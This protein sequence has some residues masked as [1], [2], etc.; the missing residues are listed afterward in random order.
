MDCVKLHLTQG[1]VEQMDLEHFEKHLICASLHL[2][3]SLN[4]LEFAQSEKEV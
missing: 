4:L 1:E 2:Y 3:I